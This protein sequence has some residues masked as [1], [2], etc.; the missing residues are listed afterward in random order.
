M[1]IL[2]V[3]DFLLDLGKS[4]TFLRVYISERITVG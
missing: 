4:L 2:K 3:Y 1:S